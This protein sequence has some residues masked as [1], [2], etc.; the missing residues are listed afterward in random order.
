[1]T[2]SHNTPPK[3]SPLVALICLAV[4]ARLRPDWV[5]VKLGDAAADSGVSPQ[6]LSRLCTRAIAPFETAVAAL[7]RIGRPPGDKAAA[8]AAAQRDLMAALLGV[9]TSL[10]SRCRPRGAWVHSLVAGAWLRLKADHPSLTHRSFC[11]ALAIPERTL[12]HWVSTAPPS[13]PKQA[14]APKAQKPNKRPPRRGRFSFAV[15]L[16]DTQT[17]A[18]T[19]DL[20][21]FDQ[22]LKLVAAQ[23]IG[24]RDIDLLDSV[25][26]EDHES[27]ELVVR[28]L[29]EA[30]KGQGAEGQQAVTDQGTPYMAQV[31]RDAL[32]QLGADHAPQREGDPLGKATIER[33]F[34]TV[35]SIAGP[36]LAIT[37]RL[38][39]AVEALRNVELAK[40][41]TTVLLTALLRAYQAG[42]RA[43][44]RAAEARTGLDEQTLVRAAQQSRQQA[45]AENRSARLLLRHI[46][47]SYQF[48]GPVTAFI[49]AFRRF[50]VVVLHRA[51]RAFATQAHRSDIH[52]RQS[53]FAAIVRRLDDEYRTELAL[54]QRQQQAMRELDRQAERREAQMQ[55]WADNPRQHLDAALVALAAQWNPSTASLLFDGAGLGRA[56]LDDALGR[57]LEMHGFATARDI[58]AG[59]FNAFARQ[60]ADPLGP[61]GIG[62]IEGMLHEHLH[63]LATAAATADCADRFAGDILRETGP[64][65]RPD[66]ASPLRT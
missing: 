22:P 28:V 60:Q 53:Y 40:A 32:E 54:K 51:E 15:T 27:A 19:T 8:Q 42:A 56:W 20:R 34:G 50:P 21:A 41:L 9:A 2:G 39:E 47:D 62:M 31:T 6:R 64:P 4:V 52:D 1:M 49:R 35:K 23:D 61:A 17:A 58:A 57:L 13:S 48:D 55:H 11:E 5:A 46:H 59:T 29:T 12:R 10:L 66:P 43:A 65:T 18:D 33:A 44:H 14:P 30:L 37:D 7:S 24:G 63:Q 45:H 38:A 3:P 36:L 26:V 16:P 25:I